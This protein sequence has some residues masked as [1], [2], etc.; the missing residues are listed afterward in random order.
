M[1]DVRSI[2]DVV[3]RWG[4]AIDQRACVGAAFLLVGL[5]SASCACTAPC[6]DCSA[7]C[8]WCVDSAGGH[9]CICVA[10]GRPVAKSS[11]GY[12]LLH[13]MI[14]SEGTLGVFTELTVRLWPQPEAVSAAVCTFGSIQ[15]L[16]DCATAVK[17]TGAP[18]ARMEVMDA[19]TVRAVNKRSGTA[20]AEAPTLLFEFVGSQAGAH[21]LECC[22]RTALVHPDTLHSRQDTRRTALLT[23]HMAELDHTCISAQRRRCTVAPSPLRP[24]DHRSPCAAAVCTQAHLYGSMHAAH[25][26]NICTHT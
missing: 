12:D 20:F 21:H 24:C 1:P 26:Y 22:V 4:H 19:L 16:V 15:D 9:A 2:G 11:A 17:Q 8:G 13:L 7:A 6:M 10:A 14:G 3:V 5:S 18:V 23:F 25:A